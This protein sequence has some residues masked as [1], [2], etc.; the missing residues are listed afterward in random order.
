MNRWR[1]APGDCKKLKQTHGIEVSPNKKKKSYFIPSAPW[2][3]HSAFPWLPHV[4]CCCPPLYHCL[5]SLRPP[6]EGKVDIYVE[7]FRLTTCRRSFCPDPGSLPLILTFIHS[8]L[9]I[10]RQV[11]TAALTFNRWDF[12]CLLYPERWQAASPNIVLRHI[13]HHAPLDA[14]LFPIDL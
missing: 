2:H 8:S 4:A 11:Q 14:A 7:A 6:Q 1:S 5:D 10:N 9:G 12:V 13:F 3:V